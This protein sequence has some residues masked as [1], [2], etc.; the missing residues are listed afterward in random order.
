MSEHGHALEWETS[1]WPI[2]VSVGI[3]LFAPLAF[4]FHFVYEKPSAAVISLAL[5]TIL[6]VISVIGWVKDGL[7]D[8]HGWGAGYSFPAMPFFILAEAFIFV[9]LFASYWVMRLKAPIWPPEG[10]PHISTTIPIIMTI[11]LVS[12]SVTIH[13]AEMQHEKGNNGGFLMWLWATIILGGVFFYLTIAEWGHLLHNGFNTTTNAYGTIFY[14]ITGLHASHVFVGVA[15]FIC[16]L[17]PAHMR[18]TNETFIKTA[19]LYWHFVDVVW[20]F[21]VSQVYFWL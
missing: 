21:V 15:I 17:I 2:I 14:S 12:S 13:L 3:L 16:I 19:S 5:G 4:S 6:I 11:I 1:P 10:T 9:A 20:F 8:K 18:K 7:E